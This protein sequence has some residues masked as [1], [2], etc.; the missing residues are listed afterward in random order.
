MSY[1]SRRLEENVEL[2][3]GGSGLGYLT[4][5]KDYG[6]PFRLSFSAGGS[7]TAWRSTFKHT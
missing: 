3:R 5:I 4:L 2:N 1:I 7:R 6:H